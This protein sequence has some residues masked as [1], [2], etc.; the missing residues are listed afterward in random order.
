MTRFVRLAVLAGAALAMLLLASTGSAQ[1]NSGYIVVLQPGVDAANEAALAARA[2]GVAV[3]HVYEHAINGFSFH[4]SAQAAAALARNPNVRYVTPDYEVSLVRDPSASKRPGGGGG[5]TTQ[6][7]QQLPT[8]IDRIDAE[9]LANN[10]A[11]VGVAVIDTGIDLTHPDLAGNNQ[12]QQGANC[13]RPGT[14]PNDDNGHGSHVAG[15]I[16]ARDNQIGV[17]G[18]APDATLYPVKV[19][20]RRGSGTW[21]S[22]ICGIDWVTSQSSAIKV[23]NMSLGGSGIPGACGAGTDALHDAICGS[24]AAGVTYV[25]A[26]GNS[27]MDASTFVPAAYAEVITV[28]AIADFNGQPGGGAAPTCR[29][30]VDDTFADFSNYGSPVDIAAPGVCTLSTWRGGGYNTISGTSMASPHVAGAAA[31]YIATHPGASPSTV[32]SALIAATT[33]GPLPGAPDA[34]K[35]CAETWAASAVTRNERP[36]GAL[37]RPLRVLRPGGRTCSPQLPAPAELPATTHQLAAQD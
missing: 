17:V 23:A 3:G 19:L 32:R 4:G 6:P 26:A 31:L 24:V 15:T 28:S 27:A 22:V 8:G 10:G 21:S 5:G 11:G 9:G 34:Q 30:D 1:Q 35:R 37:R 33:P 13:V 18:V 16:A 14:A 29:S 20:D 7:A 2:Q 36:R 25:V 12:L